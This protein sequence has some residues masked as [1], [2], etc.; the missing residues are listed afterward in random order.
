MALILTPNSRALLARTPTERT[1]CFLKTYMV[2]CRKSSTQKGA[3]NQCTLVGRLISKLKK[4]P[5]M[6]PLQ[7]TT[8]NS[9]PQHSAV[10]PLAHIFAFYML[11]G[12]VTAA[13]A[14]ATIA[15]TTTATR[16]AATVPTTTTT[17][18]T[19]TTATTAMT[20]T[21]DEYY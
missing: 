21:T 17:T 11:R 5:L 18:N 16:A 4:H 10:F 8:L 2:G 6:N 15:T 3:A 19:T 1:L 20:T 9:K 13:T 14:A 12:A 7:I